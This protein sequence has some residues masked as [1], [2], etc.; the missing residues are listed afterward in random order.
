MAPITALPPRTKYP[1]NFSRKVG[2]AEVFGLGRTQHPTSLRSVN[3]RGERE[4]EGRERAQMVIQTGEVFSSL[5]RISRY[6]TAA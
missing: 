2:E 5:L 6:A 1:E 4:R 3:Q